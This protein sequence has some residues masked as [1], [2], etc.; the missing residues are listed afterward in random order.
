MT[1]IGIH[2]TEI[3]AC[4]CLEGESGIPAAGGSQRERQNAA[5]SEFID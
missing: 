4:M 3:S 5:P 2:T 1:R